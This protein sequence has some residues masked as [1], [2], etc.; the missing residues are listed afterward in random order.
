MPVHIDLILR[1]LLMA[2]LRR[3]QQAIEHISMFWQKIDTLELAH[4]TSLALPKI[5]IGSYVASIK[6]KTNGSP[7][8]DGAGITE[9]F[10]LTRIVFVS[11]SR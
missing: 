7:R 4:P 6:S 2:T 11:I 8:L 1:I 3:G 5:H 10:R 9:L